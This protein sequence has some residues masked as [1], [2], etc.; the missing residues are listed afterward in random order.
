MNRLG[1]LPA[2]VADLAQANTISLD[3]QA[4]LLATVAEGLHRRLY[5]E[6][7]RFD[8]EIAD[9]VQAAAAEAVGSIHEKAREA[10]HGLLS[11]VEEVGYAARLTRLASVAEEV[12]PGVTGRTSKWKRLVFEVRNE[13]AHRL[14]ASFL[15]DKDIDDRLTVALSLRWL[16]T[17]VLLLQANI[18]PLLL[19][20]R[21][22]DHEPFQRFLAD[23]QVWR[24]DIYTSWL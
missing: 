24:P 2:V 16:L 18:E 8:E 20:N 17:G 19:R 15:D 10:V 23:A 3:T 12:A 11:H 5:P 6:E 14:R 9:R 13:Y 1:P 4:L 22:V 21:F 7:V